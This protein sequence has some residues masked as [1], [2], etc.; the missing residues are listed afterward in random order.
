VKASRKEY[1]N[2]SQDVIKMILSYGKPNCTGCGACHSICPQQCIAMEQDNEGFLYPSIDE[3]NCIKCAKCE[4]IC[5]HCMMREKARKPLHIYASKNP[6][7]EVRYQSSSGGVFS[8]FA[9]HVIGESGV[10]FGARFNDVWEVVHG[11]AEAS[12]D[13]AAFRGSKYV[14]SVTGDT[15]VQAKEFLESGRKVLYSGTPCQIAGL[16]AFLQR[17]YNNL[18]TVDFVCYGVPSPLVWKKYLSEI[19]D[20]VICCTNIINVNFRDKRH[21]WNKTFIFSITYSN[22]EKIFSFTEASNVNHYMRGFFQNLYLRPSCY[23][24]PVKSFKSG[25]DITVADY[26]GIKNILPEFDD[27]KGTSLVIVNTEKALKIYSSLCKN[28]FE[29]TYA[30]TLVGNPRIEVGLAFLPQERTLF[31]K[32]LYNEPVIALIKKMTSDSLCIRFRKIITILLSRFGLLNFVKS[33]LRYRW[34]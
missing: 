10:V 5:P 30:D 29:T 11:Y 6:D 26:W 12:E 20:R 25:S 21:G 31:F 19:I 14:Q 28:D 34:R 17:E 4:N 1:V 33:L 27:G 16:K 3:A 22:N 13:I 7:D 9:E 2:C 23:N 18:F 15:Y 8:L 24:C 32:K